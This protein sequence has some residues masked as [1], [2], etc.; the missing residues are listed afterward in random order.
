MRAEAG[1]ASREAGLTGL[2]PAGLKRWPRAGPLVDSTWKRIKRL[3]RMMMINF[4]AAMAIMASLA[5]R[6]A[7]KTL[8]VASREVGLAVASR[9]V[10]LAGALSRAAS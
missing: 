8:A 5:C 2:A 4:S 9:E 6:A 10:G 3:T 1:A 7:A